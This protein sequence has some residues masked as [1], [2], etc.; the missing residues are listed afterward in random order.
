[1]PVDTYLPTARL[2][3][4]LAVATISTACVVVL[5]GPY[6]VTESGLPALASI[7]AAVGVTAV[8]FWLV[9]GV[10]GW[11]LWND[12]EKF[13]KVHRY[14][15]FFVL[16]LALLQIPFGLFTAIEYLE[17]YGFP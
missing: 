6:V 13:R 17:Y 15:G 12:K 5:L 7:H 8:S 14:N 1:M 3:I 4:T 16:G 11:R 2:H 9:Q 10:L